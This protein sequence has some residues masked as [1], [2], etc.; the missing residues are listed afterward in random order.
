MLPELPSSTCHAPNR[1]CPRLKSRCSAGFPTRI[2]L[3][4]YYVH[5]CC[6]CLQ[7]NVEEMAAA[8]AIGRAS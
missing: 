5:T 3:L 1:L 4:A 7:F 6:K 2:Y 8:A